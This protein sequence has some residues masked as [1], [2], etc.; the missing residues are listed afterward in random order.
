MTFNWLG[1][2]NM[3]RLLLRAMLVPCL[4]FFILM[5]FDY[6]M[7]KKYLHLNIFFDDQFFKPYIIFKAQN[8][9]KNL[10]FGASMAE[11]IELQDKN[12]NIF[13]NASIAG[14][15]LVDINILLG[16]L[17]SINN[18][19]FIAEPYLGRPA[20]PIVKDWKS[21]TYQERILMTFHFSFFKNLFCQ[22]IT[23]CKLYANENG[24]A[25]VRSENKFDNWEEKKVFKDFPEQ[26]NID[27]FKATFS[28]AEMKSNNVMIVI[29]PFYKRR[30]EHWGL[31]NYHR[32]KEMIHSFE[33]QKICIIDFSDYSSKLNYYD[34]VHFLEDSVKKLSNNISIKIQD[35]IN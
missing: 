34:G 9:N 18:A 24:V 16:Q 33:S 14:S 20:V 17:D 21:L 2:L 6:A 35:C 25:R 28:S 15:K 12:G 8:E 27:A 5:L 11:P 13:Y 19:V 22:V 1:F 32:F 3:C 29:P 26:L 4:A 7:S 10:V 30:I 31:E 23:I